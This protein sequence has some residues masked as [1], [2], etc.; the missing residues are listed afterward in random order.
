MILDIIFLK[1]ENL[2]IDSSKEMI[3]STYEIFEI[4]LVN[5]CALNI[6]ILVNNIITDKSNF[7]LSGSCSNFDFKQ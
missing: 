7:M 2:K 3:A 4:T 6:F 1:K 5:S